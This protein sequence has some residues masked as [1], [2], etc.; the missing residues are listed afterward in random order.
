M[1]VSSLQ[2]D[3]LVPHRP[4]MRLVDRV[5]SFDAASRTLVAEAVGRREWGE[6]WAA[7]EIM[8][9]TAAA[10]AGACD[11]ESG[12]TGAARPGFLLG[13]RKLELGFDR[14]EP[15]ARYEVRAAVAYTDDESA[16]F[17]CELLRDGVRIASATLN[18]Y[19]P[20]DVKAFMEE[21]K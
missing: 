3:G 17:D 15:G 7:V 20:A 10:L 6:N 12:Y 18:A 5:V 13:T 1:P 19:R 4:P 11:R 8:A 21:R 2:L 14:F 9:Q 16:S